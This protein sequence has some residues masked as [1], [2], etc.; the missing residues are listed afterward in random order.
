MRGAAPDLVLHLGQI[1]VHVR[2]KALMNGSKIRRLTK[3]SPSGTGPTGTALTATKR[4]TPLASIAR[5]IPRVVFEATGPSLR[6]RGP[7]PEIAASLPSSAARSTSGSVRPGTVA[8]SS[9]GWLTSNRAGSRTT[10]V[11]WCPAASACRTT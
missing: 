5:R 8:T 2:A 11:T 10:A 9:A 7:T 6:P 1:R 3:L 4:R